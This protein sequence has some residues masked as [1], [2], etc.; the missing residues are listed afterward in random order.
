MD[1]EHVHKER[2]VVTTYSIRVRNVGRSPATVTQVGWQI[3]DPTAVVDMAMHYRVDE[4]GSWSSSGPVLPYRIESHGEATWTVSEEFMRRF[5]ASA[6]A[7]ALVRSAAPPVRSR[8]RPWPRRVGISSLVGDW[9]ELE[10]VGLT[11]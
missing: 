11:P 3:F 5:Y 1:S 4:E 2:E 7:R 9:I 6:R 8:L 10:R